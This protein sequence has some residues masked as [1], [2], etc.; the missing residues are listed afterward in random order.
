M[1]LTSIFGKRI[2]ETYR[3]RYFYEIMEPRFNEHISLF[4]QSLGYNAPLGNFRGNAY[5]EAELIFD[6][7]KERETYLEE[8]QEK[9]FKVMENVMEYAREMKEGIELVKEEFE[10]TFDN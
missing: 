7:I 10:K 9:R 6:F 1:F 2:E 5:T 8:E 4:L 3:I